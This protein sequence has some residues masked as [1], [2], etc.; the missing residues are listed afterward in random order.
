MD[1]RRRHRSG[2]SNYQR[3]SGTLSELGHSVLPE[4]LVLFGLIILGEGF[5]G[6]AET[7]NKISP[8]AKTHND[9]LGG[10]AIESGGWEGTPSCKL[11]AVCSSSS[12]SL[13]LLPSRDERD[14]YKIRLDRTMGLHPRTPSHVFS[15][16]GDRIEEDPELHEHLERNVRV[17]ETPTTTFR[18]R[19]NGRTSPRNKSSFHITKVEVPSSDDQRN[20]RRH[21]CYHL[22]HPKQRWSQ[23]SF[24][25]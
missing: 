21:L 5:T 13:R 19:R 22:R 17:L 20:A 16:I 25:R 3:L 1:P 14:R 10:V 2:R 9:I 4:R 24:A 18:T 7:L 12:C 6:I 15:I 11:S 23:H 8:G